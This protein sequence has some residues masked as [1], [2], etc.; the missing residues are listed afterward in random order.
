MPFGY[1]TW[2]STDFYG[3][4]ESPDFSFPVKF[5]MI[6]DG[7]KIQLKTAAAALAGVG[8]GIAA[9]HGLQGE[10]AKAAPAFGTANGQE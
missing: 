1:A 10:Q 5:P 7:T 8:I 9:M 2:A 6:A 4:V 3:A